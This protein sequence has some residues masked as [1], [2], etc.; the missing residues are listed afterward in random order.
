MSI[1]ELKILYSKI[2]PTIEYNFRWLNEIRDK[3]L[4][5]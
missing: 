4:S 5:F 1:D 2:K 3:D